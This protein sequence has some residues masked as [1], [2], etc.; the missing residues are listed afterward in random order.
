MKYIVE[1]TPKAVVLENVVGLLTNPKLKD[2][3]EGMCDALRKAGYEI[4]MKIL[5]TEEHGIAQTRKRAYI[6]GI[7]ETAKRRNFIWP[8]KLKRTVPL[9]MTLMA[10]SKKWDAT[11]FD[12]DV[13]P[14]TRMLPPPSMGKAR[15]LVEKALIKISV[16]DGAEALRH[17]TIVVDIGSSPNWLNY[18][19][20]S[21]PTV[22]RS[23]GRCAAYWVIINGIGA[24]CDCYD[25]LAIQGFNPNAFK[26]FNNVV[27]KQQIGAMAGNAMSC[28]VLERLLPAVLDSV[29]IHASNPK[30][31]L[32]EEL[33]MIR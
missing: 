24:K 33:C 14:V 23:R 10:N 25:L 15:Q 11:K 18:R 21:F 6:V 27:S 29:G 9:K 28:N 22:T 4:H 2:V 31:D 16:S 8:E 1:C 13:D 20:N 19:T 30:P 5:N 12:P 26:N 3:K 7:K 17:N 32:W